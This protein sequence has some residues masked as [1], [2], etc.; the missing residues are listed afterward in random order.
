MQQPKILQQG[1]T[2]IYSGIA[3][4]IVQQGWTIIHSGFA[5]RIVQQGRT[6]IY[7]GIE[8]KIVQQ[9]RTVIHSGIA[10]AKDSSTRKHHNLLWGK[11]VQ[12]DKRACMTLPQIPRRLLYLKYNRQFAYAPSCLYVLDLL[13]KV[14]FKVCILRSIFSEM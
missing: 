5:V 13:Y 1:S 8:A 2:I 11:N 9:G 10:A 12:K 14:Y 7:S 3:A 6:I 4:R